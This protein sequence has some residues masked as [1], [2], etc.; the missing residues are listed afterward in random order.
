MVPLLLKVGRYSGNKNY[1][2][3]GQLNIKTVTFV[4]FLSGWADE[5]GIAQNSCDS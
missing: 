3:V 5:W 2:G 4:H 1:Q